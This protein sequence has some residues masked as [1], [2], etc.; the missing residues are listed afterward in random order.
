MA[1]GQCLSVSVGLFVVDGPW[2]T[3]LYGSLVTQDEYFLKIDDANSL[4]AA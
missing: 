2:C 3:I 1:G 4:S